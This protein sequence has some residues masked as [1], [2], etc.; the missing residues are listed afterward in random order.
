MSTVAKSGWITIMLVAAAVNMA[1]GQN[2]SNSSSA[3]PEEPAKATSWRMDKT[4]PARNT[5]LEFKRLR[6]GAPWPIKVPADEAPTKRNIRFLTADEPVSARPEP[7]ISSPLEEA[8]LK[9]QPPIT[10]T[11]LDGEALV[12][13]I[14]ESPRRQRLSRLEKL[15]DGGDRFP[16]ARVHENWDVTG[17]DPEDTIAHYDT[18]SG[19]TEVVPSNRVA[20]YSPRFAAVRQV[21]NFF[22]NESSEPAG[23]VRM[24]SAPNES[25]GDVFANTVKRDEAPI[26]R[27]R[28]TVPHGLQD[29]APG[30]TVDH[31]DITRATVGHDRPFKGVHIQQADELLLDRVPLVEK[32][33]HELA[34]SN[35]IQSVQVILD[36]YRA[37]LA[38]KTTSANEVFEYELPD[39]KSRMR[40]T[41]IA[42]TTAAHIGDTVRFTI[43]FD[44]VGDEAVGNVTI[45]DN[46][47]TRFVYI[48]ESQTCDVNADFSA[49]ANQS[50]SSRLRWEITEPLEPGQGGTIRFECRVR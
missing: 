35:E 18:L 28:D 33:V 26:E 38:T 40:I 16:A 23:R 15:F 11:V 48:P 17:I 4:Q 32:Y 34:I 9:L 29:L 25:G 12:P 47:T 19:K 2:R 20:V 37:S 49:A 7:F 43:R 1:A 42:S 10:E 13:P 5:R 36:S 6:V 31:A 22:E 3:Q 8:P 14:V 39:G 44:N 24:M 21:K 50:R 45:I 41:K 27:I 30:R 46:L